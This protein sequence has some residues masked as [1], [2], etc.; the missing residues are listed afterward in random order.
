MD[1]SRVTPRIVEELTLICGKAN[2]LTDSERIESYSHDE[3]SKEQFGVM[4]EVVVTPTATSQVAQIM[5]LASKETIPVTPRGAGSGL[6]PK[7]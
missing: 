1:Y 3:T 6:S 4:P 2:V 7:S 5:R